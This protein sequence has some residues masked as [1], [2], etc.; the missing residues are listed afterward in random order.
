MIASLADRC[1]SFMVQRG[2]FN[3]TEEQREIYS[4][5]MEL[6]IHYIINAVLLLALGFFFGRFLE[7]AFF[8]FLFGLMQSNGGGY[9][10]NTHGR[11][12][13]IMACGVL[14]FLVL[15]PLYQ[16]N[17]RLQFFS[18]LIGFISVI[19]LAPVAHKNHPLNP[20]KSKRMGRRA[21]VLAVTI[22]IAWCLI[23]FVEMWQIVN[24]IVSLT[25]A[26]ISVSMVAAQIKKLKND[27]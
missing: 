1:V 21:K 25:M 14:L 9:H 2:V 6:Q 27:A 13:G 4:Y 24:S 7:V 20:E 15:L 18:A 16:Y 19:W 11:C 5:G 8:L 17:V 23:H 12:L 10:A 3:N 22:L 26:F